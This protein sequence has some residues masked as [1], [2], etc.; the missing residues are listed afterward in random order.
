MQT[1]T[2]TYSQGSYPIYIGANLLHDQALLQRHV[3]AQQVMIITNTTVAPLYLDSVLKAFA[4]DYQC[5]HLILPDGEA[6]KNLAQLSVIFDELVNQQHH[7]DTTL[8]ALGGG[9]IGDITGFAAACYH[10]GVNF[11]QI[12]TTLLSQ[13]DSSIGGKT[14]VNHAQGKNL[15]GAFH[16]PQA[17]I[18]D[19]D[20]LK[21]LPTRE[22]H[23]G[24]AET[25]KAA[26]IKDADFFH[27]LQN[28]LEFILRHDPNI[29]TTAITR[30]CQIKCNIVALDEKEQGCRAL[31]NFGHTFAHAIEQNLGYGVWLHGEAVGM[32]ML[33]AADLSV[34][35]GRLTPKALTQIRDILTQTNLPLNLPSQIKCDTLLAAMEGDKKV[36]ANQLRLILLETIGRAV[37]TQ[38]VDRNTLTQLLRD[39]I[40]K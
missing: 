8:I 34:R 38:D 27:W 24:M 3:R 13:V 36:L 6:T 15:I 23:A 7:R 17:V 29:L 9:V 19:T 31:L 35:I 1:I 20:T 30:A 32:G 12:P 11:I 18:I 26:I 28:H 14:A 37:V 40:Q 22:L 33:M 5:D 39:Y 25:I 2:A 10:R 4:N 21:T 16:Q